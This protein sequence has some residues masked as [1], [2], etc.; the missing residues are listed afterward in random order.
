MIPLGRFSVL[1]LTH[2]LGT[3][4]IG[5]GT[6]I[7][8]IDAL[9]GLCGKICGQFAEYSAARDIDLFGCR[10]CWNSISRIESLE[11]SS[12]TCRPPSVSLRYRADSNDRVLVRKSIGNCTRRKCSLCC[13]RIRTFR[14]AAPM[15]RISYCRI[16]SRGR[17]RPVQSSACESVRRTLSLD[18]TFL[19]LRRRY[20]RSDTVQINRRRNR[21]LPR[22]RDAHR[23][24]NDSLWSTERTSIAFPLSIT[25][26]RRIQARETQ[27]W[28]TTSTG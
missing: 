24:G 17:M 15:S 9:D 7:R 8:E 1:K 5:K 25:Q 21:D 6:L 3:G 14:S 26:R 20:G 18:Y 27:D 2:F 28:Y 10:C 13:R 12:C 23:T 16:R 22:R 4:G 11:R 19:I